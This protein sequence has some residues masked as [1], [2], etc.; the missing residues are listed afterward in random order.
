[1]GIT[2]VDLDLPIWSDTICYTELILPHP[3]VAERAF[4][5]ERNEI[6]HFVGP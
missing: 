3:G 5:L 1:M 4:V 6:A 2:V